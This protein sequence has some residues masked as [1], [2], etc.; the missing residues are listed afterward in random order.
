MHRQA[1]G[2]QQAQQAVAVGAGGLQH[3]A[4]L[5]VEECAQHACLTKLRHLFGADLVVARIGREGVDGEHVQLQRHAAV[6]GKRH[7]AGSGKE[8]AVGTVMVGQQQPFGLCLAHGLPELHEQLRVV[9]V[10]NR[11]AVPAGD[12]GQGRA[13]QA[14]LAG[15][16]VHQDEAGLH[17]GADLGRECPAHVAD[18]GMGGDDQRYRRADFHALSVVTLPAGAHGKRILA[19]R[20]ADAQL[21]AQAAGCFHGGVEGSVLPGAA[22]IGH[23]V[24]RQLGL[25]QVVRHGRQQ[26]GQGFGNGQARGGSRVLHGHGRAFAHGECVAVVVAVVQ[27]AHGA[28]GHGHLPRTHHRVAHRQAAH[29]A[30]GDGDEEALAGH[31]RQLQDLRGQRVQVQLAQVHAR[32]FGAGRRGALAAQLGRLAEQHAHVDV[33]GGRLARGCQL[34]V[35]GVGDGADHGHRAALA[36]AQG[37]QLGQ[38]LGGDA[39][40]VA[41]LRLVAPDLGRRHAAFGHGDAAQVEVRALVGVM[42][43]FGEGVGQAARAHVVDGE[44]G[45]VVA[46]GAAGVDHFLHAALHLGVGALHRGEVQLGGIAAHAHA[47]GGTAAQADAHARAA[48]LHEQRA[49][50]QRQLVLVAGIHRTHA[51]GD[52]DGLVVAPAGVRVV[53]RG[54]RER[55]L[56]GA[57]VAQQVRAAEFVVEGGPAQRA[58]DHDGQRGGQGGRPAVGGFPGVFP[59]G[60]AQV[61]DGEAG[62]A[63]ARRAAPAGGAFVTDLAATAGGCARM[64]GNGRGVVVGLDLQQAMHRLL[65]P[66][67]AAGGRVHVPGGQRAAFQNGGVVGIGH[68]RALRVGLVGLADHAEE[69]A[70]LRLAVD[71]EVGVE[72]LVAA[73]LGVGLREH[74]QLDIGGVASQ[75]AIDAGQVVD[76]VGRQRQAQPGV[77]R[78]QGGGGIVAQRHGGQGDRGMGRKETGRIRC[79]GEPALGHRVMQAGGQ[80]GE[81]RLGIVLGLA[82]AQQAVPKAQLPADA[83]LDARHVGK[84]GMVQDVDGLGRPGRERALT[85]RDPEGALVLAVGGIGQRVLVHQQLQ[86]GQPL[87][88]QGAIRPRGR[89]LQRVEPFGIEG[90]DGIVD[91]LQFLQQCLGTEGAQCMPTGQRW[92]GRGAHGHEGPDR[93]SASGMNRPAARRVAPCGG[94]FQGVIIG[95]PEGVPC[96]AMQGFSA[97]RRR[98]GR[99]RVV[100]EHMGC[101]ISRTGVVSDLFDSDSDFSTLRRHHP[102][103]TCRISSRN[104]AAPGIPIW[105][106]WTRSRLTLARWPS[107]SRR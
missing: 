65:G 45:V 91:G 19:H 16:Q 42:G 83:A 84:A 93:G 60:N 39:Q 7:L 10:G 100:K 57:E 9:Q 107:G 28:V 98:L 13:A 88:G 75:L 85:G 102:C 99:S 94:V 29:G 20:D 76:L 33:D 101:L 92:I 95:K 12:L 103:L 47:G 30:V 55:G 67:I 78:A 70:F 37:F 46:H 106:R 6:T 77:G 104:P 73:V 49:G 11:V 2:T 4:R 27:Q 63:V 43:Q 35:L 90:L 44:D 71:D 40:H 14:L 79:S 54:L 59:A 66:A 26:V 5:L 80:Q 21:D 32:Q 87:T 96:P 3:D 74:H 24:G 50:R 34:Q 17:L 18:R 48:Q 36:G 58:L 15:A 38:P 105:R 53:G 22:G 86:A 82:A 1:V 23:P 68:H 69:R 89:D 51:T 81:L 61:G 56:E 62:E 41:F 25:A 97:V 8:S 31:G 52:H 72:D 64:G